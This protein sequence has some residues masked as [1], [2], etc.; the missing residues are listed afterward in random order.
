LATASQKNYLISL[1]SFAKGKKRAFVLTTWAP[2]ENPFSGNL[3]GFK[4]HF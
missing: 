2:L 1:K 4:A 3:F